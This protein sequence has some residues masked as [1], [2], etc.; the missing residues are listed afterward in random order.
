VRKRSHSDEKINFGKKYE[1]MMSMLVRCDSEDRR[2]E[3]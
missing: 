2:K 3:I 1:K